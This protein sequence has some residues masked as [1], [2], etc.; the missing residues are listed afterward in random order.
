[1]TRVVRITSDDGTDVTVTEPVDGRPGSVRGRWALPAPGPCPHSHK[2][3]LD[4]QRYETRPCTGQAG[5]QSEEHADSE[6]RQ[7]T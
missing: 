5:H 3:W 1:M 7:W 6:G 4:G 2:V